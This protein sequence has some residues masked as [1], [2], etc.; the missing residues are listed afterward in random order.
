MVVGFVEISVVVKILGSS[1]VKLTDLK[2]KCRD[3]YL[4]HLDYVVS[5]LCK[6]RPEKFSICR[7]TARNAIGVENRGETGHIERQDIELSAGG[8]PRWQR[9]G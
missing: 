2:E 8:C 1:S 4:L 7:L 3:S 5:I 6:L 9:K